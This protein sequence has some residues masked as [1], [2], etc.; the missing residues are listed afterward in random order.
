[1]EKTITPKDIIKINKKKIVA[2]DEIFGEYDIRDIMPIPFDIFIYS[3][4]T[5]SYEGHGFGAW[6]NGKD[7][8]YHEMGHCSCNGP[9]DGINTSKQ[10]AVTY[11]QL[12]AIAEKNYDDHGKLVIKYIEEN[13]V[14]N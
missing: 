9:T 12:K 11:E 1:M 2:L 5:G 6:K 14:Q 10:A 3:Y 4:A 13:H 8:F 7:W